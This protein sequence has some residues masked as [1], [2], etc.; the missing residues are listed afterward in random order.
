MGQSIAGKGKSTQNVAIQDQIIHSFHLP[1][2]LSKKK[3]KKKKYGRA[4]V[5]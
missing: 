1:H 3:K 5:F 4:T 2:L